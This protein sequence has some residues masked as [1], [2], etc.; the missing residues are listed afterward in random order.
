VRKVVVSQFVSLDGVVEDPSS[1]TFQFFGEEQQKYKLDELAAADVLL[2]GRVTYEEFAAA[3]PKMMEQYEGPGRAELGEYAD[4][5]NGYPKFVV[6]TTLREAEWNNSTVITGNVADEVCRLKQQPGKDI[7]V[8]GS[9]ELVNA[10]VRHGLVDEFRL[11][12]FPILLGGGKRLFDDAGE[13]RALSLV[14]TKTF[15]TNVVILTYE[16]AQS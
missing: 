4:M 9:T 7:L 13:Q 6:S 3:W 2:L 5:M 12:V 11:M 1:W 14:D 10:L 8:F 15:G 16:P